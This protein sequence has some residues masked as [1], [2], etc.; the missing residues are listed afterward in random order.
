MGLMMSQ[1]VKNTAKAQPKAPVKNTAKAQ[2]KAPVGRPKAKVTKTKVKVA[3]R[4]SRNHSGDD[5]THYIGAADHPDW[6][7]HMVS[8][9]RPWLQS[10]PQLCGHCLRLH[11]WADCAGLCSEMCAAQ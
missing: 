8:I 4:K 5:L 7:T 1:H 2:P 9:L 3:Q 10:L 6:A 11:V